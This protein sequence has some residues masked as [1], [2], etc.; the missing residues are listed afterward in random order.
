MP[1]ETRQLSG[2]Q[3]LAQ[4]YAAEMLRVQPTGHHFLMGHG[5]GSS[6]V[7]TAVAHCLSALGH[8]PLLVSTELALLC[9]P[10]LHSTTLVASDAATPAIQ[11]IIIG[12]VDYARAV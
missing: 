6:L 7:A 4:L 10:L 2:L 12:T 8:K 11:A 5:L 9:A 1:V 3:D